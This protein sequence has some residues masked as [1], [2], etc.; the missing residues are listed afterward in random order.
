MLAHDP[1]RIKLLNTADEERLEA[2]QIIRLVQATGDKESIN[3]G[4]NICQ[5]LVHKSPDLILK[6]LVK[7]DTET[8]DYIHKHES[9]KLWEAIN[10]IG[11]QLNELNSK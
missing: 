3:L 1:S 8:R 6:D 11:S 2:L 10:A 9:I 7:F 5:L 4:H